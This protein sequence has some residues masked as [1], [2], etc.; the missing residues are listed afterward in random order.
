MALQDCV[1][2][3]IAHLFDIIVV[4]YFPKHCNISIITCCH[5]YQFSVELT[6]KFLSSIQSHGWSLLFY[7]L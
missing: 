3:I 1:F 5:S 4:Q 7:S 2:S 6:A